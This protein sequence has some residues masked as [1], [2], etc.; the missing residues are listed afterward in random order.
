MWKPMS[1]FSVTPA[2]FLPLLLL[3]LSLSTSNEMDSSE[4]DGILDKTTKTEIA[5]TVSSRYIPRKCLSFQRYVMLS[6]A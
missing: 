4:E 6:P 1:V 2:S 5:C 3:K